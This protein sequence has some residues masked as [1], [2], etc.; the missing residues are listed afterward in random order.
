MIILSTLVNHVNKVSG[1]RDTFCRGILANNDGPSSEWIL[2]YPARGPALSTVLAPVWPSPVLGSTARAI[3]QPFAPALYRS[4]QRS[5]GRKQ[6]ATIAGQEGD[7][8]CVSN[9]APCRF[10]DAHSCGSGRSPCVCVTPGFHRRHAVQQRA[11]GA[12]RQC[13]RTFRPLLTSMMSLLVV[14]SCVSACDRAG[15]GFARR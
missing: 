5:L 7:A 15:R 6:H 11:S 13:H 9:L 3:S 2:A 8:I 12:P 1:R 14:P 4:C 10:G